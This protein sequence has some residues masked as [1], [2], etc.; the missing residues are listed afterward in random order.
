MSSNLNALPPR[1]E[2]TNTIQSQ[3]PFLS[4][5]RG[6]IPN[7]NINLGRGRMSIQ[8][9]R[10]QEPSP[11]SPLSSKCPSM[12]DCLKAQMMVHLPG[13]PIW[14]LSNTLVGKL[15]SKYFYLCLTWKWCHMT[16]NFLLMC[17]AYLGTLPAGTF[18]FWSI[19]LLSG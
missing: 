2:F 10:L 4:S 17:L 14:S 13:L 11:E 18:I 1:D 9:S 19:I 6:I 15:A 12:L 5:D 3:E 16:S 8:Q 7:G